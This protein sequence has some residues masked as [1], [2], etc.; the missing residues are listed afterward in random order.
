[1]G[2]SAR[3]NYRTATGDIDGAIDDLVA[4]ERFGCHIGPGG[5]LVQML[6]GIAIEGIAG[7]SGERLHSWRVVLLPYLGQ[8]ELYEKI[9]LDQPWDSPWQFHKE[10]GYLLSVPQRRS[11]AGPD[12]LLGGRRSRRTI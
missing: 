6:V 11:I 10:G 3:A 7:A 2:L 4:C 8:Q 12:D 9:R 5:F 1:L